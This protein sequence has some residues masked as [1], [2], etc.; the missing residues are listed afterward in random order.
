MTK[1][2]AK[3]KI[4]EAALE[5]AK[6][7]GALG[8]DRIALCDKA[9]INPGSF[10]YYAGKSFVTYIE[11]LYLELGSHDSTPEKSRMSGS[12]RRRMFVDI[13][14]KLVDQEGFGALT[15]TKIGECAGV[16]RS[17]IFTY[18]N[19][20]ED[21][22]AQVIEAAIAKGKWGVVAK[23]VALGLE[24]VSGLSEETKRKAL[25]SVL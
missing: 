24:C 18:F 6:D 5:M 19:G 11:E 17:L 2:D 20:I 21:L 22:H 4:R 23:A 12:L 10:A 1:D 16:T 14:V 13:A 25:A 7:K 15:S 8:I 3:Q 9:G